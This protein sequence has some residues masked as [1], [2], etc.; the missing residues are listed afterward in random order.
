MVTQS[1]S[2]ATGVIRRNKRTL[3]VVLGALQVAAGSAVAAA[4]HLAEILGP[5]PFAV[6]MIVL[7]VSST[8]LGFV[9]SQLEQE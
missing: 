6:A 5:R 3:L 1:V 9:K 2:A 7:G 8:V 4:P